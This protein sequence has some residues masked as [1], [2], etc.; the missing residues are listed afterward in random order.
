[1]GKQFKFWWRCIRHAWRGCW[2]R[3]N[4]LAGVLGAI[5]LAMWASWSYMT[6]KGRV[7]APTTYEGVAT[8]TAASAVASL[9]LA[10]VLIFATR[11][12]L[13]PR[14][15]VLGRAHARGGPEQGPAACARR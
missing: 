7:E 10:F 9:V 1:M 2:T 6:A 14:E 12:I 15:A 3:A 11:F 13:A 8:L 5:L 4:E